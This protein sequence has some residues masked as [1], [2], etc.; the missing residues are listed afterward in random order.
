M[1]PPIRNEWVRS[2]RGPVVTSPP[3]GPSTRF[4]TARLAREVGLSNWIKHA[5]I[6]G[7]QAYLAGR[8]SKK[9]YAT[10]SSPLQGVVR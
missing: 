6:V 8:M 9:L 1:R 5:V 2:R 4:R 10:A 7:R 3:A